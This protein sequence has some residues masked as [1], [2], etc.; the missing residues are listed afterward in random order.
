MNLE[1][2]LSSPVSEIANAAK[3]LKQVIVDYQ[4]KA[5]SREEYFE[6]ASNIL[7][8]KSIIANVSDMNTRQEIIDAFSALLM[9]VKSVPINP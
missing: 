1:N 2:Y 7:D 4:D 3:L 6:L 9:I 8:Y 5:V